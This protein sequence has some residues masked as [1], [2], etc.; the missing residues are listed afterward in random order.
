[1]ELLDPLIKLLYPEERRTHR[2]TETKINPFV[3]MYYYII[4]FPTQTLIKVKEHSD[5][6]NEQLITLYFSKISGVIFDGHDPMQTSKHLIS[7]LHH[8][9]S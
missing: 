4:P 1:M 8:S 5:G 6:K 3:Q 7:H 9:V 2:Q